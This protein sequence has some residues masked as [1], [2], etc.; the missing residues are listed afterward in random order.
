MAEARLI[1]Q[2]KNGYAVVFL[3]TLHKAFP[4]AYYVTDPEHYLVRGPFGTEDEAAVAASKA[5]RDASKFVNSA[6]RNRRKGR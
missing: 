4:A 5:Q 2:Y 1:E 3:D 6:A